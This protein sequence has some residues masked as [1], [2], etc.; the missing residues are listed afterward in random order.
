[1]MWARK[2]STELRELLSIKAVAKYWAEIGAYRHPKNGL[3]LFHVV[4]RYNVDAA[5]QLS[6]LLAGHID[7]NAGSPF[8]TPLFFAQQF[9]FSR[10][11]QCC[12]L[13]SDNH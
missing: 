1:M 6:K 13:D 4:C 10:L 9:V 3:S 11:S 7:V 8:G 5:V 12:V 2:G